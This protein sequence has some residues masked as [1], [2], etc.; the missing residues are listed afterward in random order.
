MER[1]PQGLQPEQVR[2]PGAAGGIAPP[3]GLSQQ[4]NCL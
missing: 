4:T 3:H 2:S 1:A